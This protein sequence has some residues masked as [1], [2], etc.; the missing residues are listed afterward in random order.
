MQAGQETVDAITS[1]GWPRAVYVH[2]DVSKADQVEAMVAKAESEFGMPRWPSAPGLL[3]GCATGKLNIIFNNAGIMHPNV[4]L[5]VLWCRVVRCADSPR[6][7]DDISSTEERVWDLTMNINLKVGPPPLSLHRAAQL[8]GVGV[9]LLMRSCAGCVVWLPRGTSGTASRRW[10]E[11][12]QHG[13]VCGAAGR[14]NQPVRL[15]VFSRQKQ[16]GDGHGKG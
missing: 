15:Y 9:S 1:H 3:T 2:C 12:H 8:L 10:W 5:S 7:D 16:I 14:G 6:Q 11:H 13:V 4:R